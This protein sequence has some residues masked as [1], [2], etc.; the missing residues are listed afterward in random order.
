MKTKTIFN[1]SH[2]DSQYQKWVG[3][4]SECGKWGS[5]EETTVNQRGEEKNNPPSLQQKPPNFPK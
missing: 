5:V 4:C 3:R 2:C 1:C